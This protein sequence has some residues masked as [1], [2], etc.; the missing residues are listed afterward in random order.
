MNTNN[1][2]EIKM[3]F[4]EEIVKELKTLRQEIFE[5][6]DRVRPE[7]EYYDLKTACAI[8]GINYHTA[9]GKHKYQPNNGVPDC[10]VG[11]GRRWKRETIVEWLKS[12]DDIS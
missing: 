3:P 8:K 6:K 1:S 11:G 9:S 10:Y 4:L 5:L 7:R 2:L 12:V